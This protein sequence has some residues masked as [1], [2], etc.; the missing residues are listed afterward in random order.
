MGR[1]QSI[2]TTCLP[3]RRRPAST[4]ATSRPVVVVLARTASTPVVAVLPVVSTTSVPT[5]TS[6]TPV[7]SVRWV[8]G[9]STSSRTTSG[10]PSS[11][12]S[13]SATARSSARAAS[14]P[15]LSSSAPATSPRTLSA[16]SRRLA[17]LSSSPLKR[18]TRHHDDT[19]MEFPSS[20]SLTRT[21]RKKSLD[22][23][24]VKRACD[25][26]RYPASKMVGSLEVI[27]YHTLYPPFLQRGS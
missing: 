22:G 23:Q 24:S 21:T 20:T 18:V 12:C 14:P 8:C 4:V 6:T 9:T 17:V 5:W 7:T 11:T 1:A 26:R 27:T 2:L 13:R 25:E 15:S 19:T 10:S 3:G 16:R